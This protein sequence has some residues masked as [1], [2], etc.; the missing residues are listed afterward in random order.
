MTGVVTLLLDGLPLGGAV[1]D[2]KVLSGRGLAGKTA[3]GA[4]GGNEGKDFAADPDLVAGDPGGLQSAVFFPGKADAGF[5]KAQVAERRCDLNLFTGFGFCLP[6][7]LL[8]R[9]GYVFT[10]AGR[11]Q[12]D[13]E[14]HQYRLSHGR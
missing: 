11:R 14:P 7:L 6:V 3:F 1:D 5:Q 10:G 12:Q 2:V 8:Q 4:L 9:A 13:G